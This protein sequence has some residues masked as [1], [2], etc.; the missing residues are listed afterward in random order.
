[1]KK[2]PKNF[3]IGNAEVI[4]NNSKLTAKSRQSI[5]IARAK[6]TIDAY[7]SDWNDFCDWCEYHNVSSFPALPETIINYINDLADNAKANTVSRRIS[8]LTENFDAA[9]IKDN[10]CRFPIVKNALRGIKRMKGT[11]QHGKM[12]ILFDDIKEMMNCLEGNE[13]Q[14]A[15]DKAIL[16]IGFYGAMRR[17]EL[18]GLDVEDLRFTRL[19]LLITLRKS[20]TDQYDQGQQIGIPFVAD[21]EVCG[22]TALRQWLQLS[23]ITTGPVFRGF[24]RSHT[25]R[26]T[27]ISD[28]SI[29]LIV[30]QYAGLVGMD[31]KD[32]GAHSLRHGFATSAAQHHVEER[33]IMHQTRHK[34]QAIVRRYIDEADSLIDNPIF[35]ITGD[36]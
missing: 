12:P 20:K 33:Q 28:K 3:F 32:Y 9:G 4:A 15:R 31:P 5:Y 25:I 36:K 6:N 35:K 26:K 23:G 14:Q 1:M 18:A 17:S 30:K 13:L 19:G 22:V 27:R 21:K 34:S 7:E 10:P 11:M 8:A 2:T 16:L 29:A 24:T